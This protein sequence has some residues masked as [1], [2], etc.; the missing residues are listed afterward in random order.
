MGTPFFLGY[1]FF[2]SLE[3]NCSVLNYLRPWQIIFQ[4]SVPFSMPPSSVSTVTGLRILATSVIICLFYIFTILVGVIRV[5][6]NDMENI[7]GV[8]LDFF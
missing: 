3:R 5:I 1:T 8:M 6:L 4:E 2:I 7:L